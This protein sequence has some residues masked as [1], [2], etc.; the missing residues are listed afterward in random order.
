MIFSLRKRK[1]ATK[2]KKM[3]DKNPQMLKVIILE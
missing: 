2:R 1:N 3:F